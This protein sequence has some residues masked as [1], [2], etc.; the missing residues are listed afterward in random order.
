M[1]LYLDT[2]SL[3]KASQPQETIR[4]KHLIASMGSVRAARLTNKEA[5]AHVDCR[6]AAGKKGA[7][8]RLEVMHVRALWR[9]ARTKQPHG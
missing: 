1:G 3:K 5:Q 2:V 7:T 6:L 8:I 4:T 9:H